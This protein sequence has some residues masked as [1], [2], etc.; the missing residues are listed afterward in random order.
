MS[1]CEATCTVPC[2]QFSWNEGSRHCYTTEA[3]A[4]TGRANPR[5]ISGC[6]RDG[7][8]SGC[9]CSF[10]ATGLYCAL[11]ENDGESW[12]HRRLINDDLTRKG[13]LWKAWTGAR[14]R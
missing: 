8:T 11:S 7:C 6:R 3:Q 13:T 12:T 10:P 5:V 9:T 2:N 4:V 14:L 1:A